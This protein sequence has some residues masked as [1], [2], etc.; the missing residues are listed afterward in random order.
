[1]D[2]SRPMNEP[3]LLRFNG[4]LSE[5]TGQATKNH[6][7]R[8]VARI[9]EEHRVQRQKEL[10]ELLARQGVVATQATVSR[11]LEE[12]GAFKVRGPDG[13]MSY[14]LPSPEEKP[15]SGSQLERVLGEWVGAIERSGDLVVV[16]TPPG[17]AHVVG[18]AIDRARVEGIL[19]TVAGDDTLLV[20]ARAR[21]GPQVERRLGEL[22]GL[23]T[24]RRQL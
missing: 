8:L 15:T 22:A 16:R 3:A 24:R 19:G 14:A 20:V 6:R 12:L 17:C 23:R 4:S 1:M 21:S 7:L 2:A 13:K 5:Q 10:V 9:L 18:S 11:D